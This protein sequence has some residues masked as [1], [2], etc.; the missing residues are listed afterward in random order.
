MA[1]KLLAFILTKT[2]GHPG[3]TISWMLTGFSGLID[4]T[5]FYL[6]EP[7]VFIVSLTSQFLVPLISLSDDVIF[8][9]ITNRF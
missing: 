4:L 6:G 7:I 9:R 2:G 8:A 3:N 5:L 1:L